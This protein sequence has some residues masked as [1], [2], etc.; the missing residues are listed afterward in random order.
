MEYNIYFDACAVVISLI[1]II[2]MVL[3]KGTRKASN[4]VFLALLVCCFLASI[5]D[6]VSS[7]YDTNPNYLYSPV[8]AFWNY[9]FLSIHLTMAFFA[10]LYVIYMLNL[11]GAYRKYG[12]ALLAFPL[13]VCI[14]LI[15]TDPFH[16]MICRESERV[17]YSHGPLFAVLY[18]V[19]FLYLLFGFVLVLRY[20]NNVRK[21]E[22]ILLIVFIMFCFVPMVIQIFFPYNLIELFFQSIGM[23]L[24]LLS[25]DN[26]SDLLRY[27]TGHDG[28]SDKRSLKDKWCFRVSF[29]SL[30][31]IAICIGIN[32]LGRAAAS[33]LNL[34]LWL[35]AVGT[36]TSAICLGPIGGGLTGAL[37]NLIIWAIKHESLYYIFVNIGVGITVGRF[38][39]R[40]KKVE[41]FPAIAT[42]VLAGFVAV[43]LSTPVNMVIYEGMSGNIWG[44]GLYAMLYRNIHVPVFCSI[45]GEAFVDMPDKAISMFLALA[46]SILPIKL[47][48]RSEIKRNKKLKF[49]PSAIILALTI[50][51]MLPG[52][53]GLSAEDRAKKTIDYESRFE[54]VTY[55]T[56]DGLSCAEINAIAQTPDGYIWTGTYSGIYRFDGSRFEPVK[57]DDRINNVMVL[58]VDSKGRLWIG[59]NDSGVGC[60]DCITGKISFLDTEGGLPSDSIRAITEDD[61]GNIYIGTSGELA[62]VNAD[63]QIIT[64]ESF[65]G[66]TG[67]RSLSSSGNVIAGVN[68]SGELFFAENNK[69][70]ASSY[71]NQGVG[72]LSFCAV[73]GCGDGDFLVGTSG[74]KLYRFSYKDGNIKSG[75]EIDTGLLNYYN[76][77]YYDKEADGFFLCCENG[78]GFLD[79]DGKLLNMSTNDF[80]SSVSDVT[81]DYQNNIWV[82]SNK[83]GVVEYAMTPFT[84]MF[85]FSG[86]GSTVVNALSIRGDD[87]IVGTDSGMFALDKKSGELKK[88]KYLSCADGMRVRHIM[89]DSNDNMWVSTYGEAGLI[90]IDK[91][92]K[93][94]TYD[95][96]KG[97]MGSRFRSTL[98]LKDGSIV[99]ASNVGLTFFKDGEITGT[100]GSEDGLDTPQILSMIET[101][102][103]SILC[104]SDGDGVYIVKNGRMAGRIDKRDGLD[105]LV[106]LRI[107]PY[108][109]GYFYVTSNALY[110]DDGSHKK[111]VRLKNFPYSNNYDIY[112]AG[113]GKIWI[114]S[115]AGIYITDAAELIAGNDIS[116][117]LL[118]RSRGFYTTLT[119]NAW[120]AV[121]GT[122]LYLCC[123]DG[124]K[125]IDTANY[126][127]YVGDFNIKIN[128]VLSGDNEVPLENG[129]YEL[130]E[131]EARIKI[132]VAVLNFT[133]SN[134][135]ISLTLDGSGDEGMIC[136]QNELTPL[137][138]TNLPYGDYTLY[139]R[140]LA[141]NTDE[142]VRE[143]S[144]K[145]HKNAQ[146][147]EKMYFKLYLL[148]VCTVFVAFLVWM[149]S[150]LGSMAIINRQYD[151]INQAKK[152]AE[153]A[154]Q[155]KSKFL[156][157]M[158]HEIRTPI[159][160]ILGMDELILRDDINSSVREYA[161]DIRQAS[162]ALLDLVNDILD[163]SKIEA[164]KMEII[165]DPYDT[166]EL[167]TS[168]ATMHKV[169]AMKAGL[170]FNLEV[171]SGIPSV[172]YGDEAK[173]RQ[174]L[175][176]LLSNAVKYTE[177]GSVSFT[178]ELLSKTDDSVRIKYKVSD[179]GIGIKPKDTENL[180]EAYR[181]FDENAHKD[182]QG[183][184]LGLSITTELLELMDSKLYVESV[185]GSGS[186]FSFDLVQ[187]FE[188]TDVLGTNWEKSHKEKLKDDSEEYISMFT[189]HKAHILIVDDNDMN[190]M[191]AAGLLKPT[192]M[193]TDTALSG[194][195][196]LEKLKEK[197]YDLILLDHMM[198]EMDGIETLQKMREMGINTTAIVLT[199][200]ATPGIRSMYIEKGF[201]DY[202][203]KPVTGRTLEE[204]IIK[205][206]P[207][208]LIDKERPVVS[209]P[210]VSET[211]TVKAQNDNVTN[212][213]TEKPKEAGN[214]SNSIIEK[215]RDRE[216]VNIADGLSYC[217]N[218]EGYEMALEIYRDG[219]DKKSAEIEKF[220]NEG[221]MKNFTVK[222]HALKSS[223]RTIGLHV[224]SE[225]ARLLEE[226]GKNEDKAY[227]DEH[228]QEVLDMYRSYK[229]VL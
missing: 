84:D 187:K 155:A 63:M 228:L 118:N 218:E 113:G 138:F 25:I 158:S 156:A 199:A 181:R 98:E 78:F 54:A 131:G 11:E 42:A 210:P 36:I 100:L 139:V 108:G 172:M 166:A 1:A 52:L 134:P 190:L 147:Y 170:D 163:L 182:I 183:T 212:N 171:S 73:C 66:V 38:F 77:I 10:V 142:V 222:A 71:L 112:D 141:D 213:N 60:Y 47:L 45:C 221:N 67:T 5:T 214:M 208:S 205:Y 149:I 111:V 146:I 174:I 32:I 191:V 126:N 143:E 175:V 157:S 220:Y 219:I 49:T 193:K 12:F 20:K 23:F 93:I 116:Y 37:T 153:E 72:V 206:L 92:E 83:Q 81:K 144:F 165:N 75:D 227:I 59:T 176:N 69:F 135:R 179:T 115:S 2:Y 99:A 194:E 85:S 9:V 195:E 217:G 188:G 132:S 229:E 35:D 34:P 6:I 86:V 123:S 91:N 151:Q 203:S 186:T 137:N 19:G 110:Y 96:N 167:L 125:L 168:V 225:K 44:D 31:L 160:A 145:F 204:T 61:K 74:N 56:N 27:I 30:L 180:G 57:L 107:V 197:R 64:D 101:A 177:K 117:E 106:I 43:V 169:R 48:K 200:N 173:L 140:I 21:V 95:E 129:V 97:T 189:A 122:K 87:L 41:A 178:V 8:K 104:G 224:L 94:T 80:D 28:S 62:V 76:R 29:L 4:K 184:G 226:A 90:C 50:S 70:L 53:E 18:A 88:D 68:N 159:N 39:P 154:N 133:L 24:I 22:Y 65:D 103:G 130:P 202:I 46:L 127:S 17:L 105:S 201:A 89:T 16:N 128:S 215:I 55:D 79:S 207:A 124:V 13:F 164:G 161:T 223:S 3:K 40:G 114:S 58:F 198:P 211:A 185:Y 15:L 26:D 102:D 148:A 51:F 216:D 120:N 152:E 82:V 136:T 150:K 119:A 196:C 121:E 7:L 109:K 14:L 209:K 33:A 192:L 162:N